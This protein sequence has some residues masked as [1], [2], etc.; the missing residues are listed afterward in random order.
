VLKRWD[1]REQQLGK[2]EQPP[3]RC[4]TADHDGGPQ[5]E[6]DRRGDV[7]LEAGGTAQ[8][9]EE[10]CEDS[11]TLP[12]VAVGDPTRATFETFDFTQEITPGALAAMVHLVL[13]R[14]PITHAEG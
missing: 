14:S 10:A 5:S 3:R 11:E 9:D 6:I 7:T 8:P 4:P 2:V 13:P 1:V 12:G